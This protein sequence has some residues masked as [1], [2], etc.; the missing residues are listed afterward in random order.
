LPPKLESSDCLLLVIPA[1]AGIQRLCFWSV[2][3]EEQKLPLQ[4]A[5]N[6]LLN[7]KKSPKNVF[8]SRTTLS[9]NSTSVLLVA[10]A[11]IPARHYP[12]DKPARDW[13]QASCNHIGTQCM[14][15]RPAKEKNFFLFFFKIG[16]TLKGAHG[17][18]PVRDCHM[19]VIIRGRMTTANN[20]RRFLV[21]F[22]R[23]AKSYPLLGAEALALPDQQ[24]KSKGAGFP[25]S[26]E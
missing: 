5:G 17:C 7:G 8:F 16:S 3:L 24:S 21:T 18:A 22:C 23:L 13:Y 26:R 9:A 10:D 2:E 6:F 11:R 1:K 25:P 20:K 4:G 15:V 19:D 14:P 12:R